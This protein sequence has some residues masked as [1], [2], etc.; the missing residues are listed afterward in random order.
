[1]NAFLGKGCSFEGKLT[2][3]GKVRVDGQFTGEIHTNDV[4]EIGPDAEV[5]AELHV[6][7]VIV[8]GKIIGNIHAAKRADLLGTASLQGNI[9]APVVTM[10]EGALIDG[11]LQMAGGAAARPVDR[12]ADRSTDR[13][14]DRQ[15]VTVGDKK[16]NKPKPDPTVL[17]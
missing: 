3:E 17:P 13:S 16:D 2:F 8:G 15:Q 7:A 11:T 5:K 12:P 1:M 6:G 4:L 10:Q 9:K 14:A